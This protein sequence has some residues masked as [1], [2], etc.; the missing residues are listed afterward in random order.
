MFQQCLL[1]AVVRGRALTIIGLV[2]YTAAKNVSWGAL[3]S[4]SPKKVGKES[5]QRLGRSQII[6]Y[7]ADF[8]LGPNLSQVP[9]T[10]KYRS[11]AG[12]KI[13]RLSPNPDA[14]LHSLPISSAFGIR[15]PNALK[16]ARAKRSSLFSHLFP[17]NTIG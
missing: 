8:P 4:G 14:D 3:D 1:T 10:D 5:R 13:I 17:Y 7:L 11:N 15:T 12:C 9:R 6:M 16:F 2:V